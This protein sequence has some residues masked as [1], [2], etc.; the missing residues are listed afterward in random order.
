LHRILEL[1]DLRAENT[2]ATWFSSIVFLAVSLSFVLLGWSYS[3][4]F[5]LS[6][7]ARFVFQ[8]TAI[9][10][11]LLSADEVASIHETVGKWFKRVIDQLWSQA[12]P[13]DRGYSWIILFAPVLLAGFFALIY[14]LRQ[15]IA[16]MDKQRQSAF[17]T[18]F[19]ALVCLPGVFVFEVFEWW[20]SSFN[21]GISI[22]TCFEEMFELIGMYSLFLC[23][24]FIARQHQL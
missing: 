6:Q 11:L 9:G 3:A 17:L 19:I 22:L 23:A 15:V 24:V 7:W 8:L 13:D 5:T 20:L 1:L 4:S 16:T 21:Q 18:L 10:A 12:P 14:F 2:L